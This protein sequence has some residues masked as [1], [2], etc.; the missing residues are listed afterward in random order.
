MAYFSDFERFEMFVGVEI[1]MV[2]KLIQMQFTK[3][4]EM[5]EKSKLTCKFI[6]KRKR[7]GSY[8]FKTI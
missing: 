3:K 5:F 6:W 1:S 8:Q 7:D 4:H 2:F